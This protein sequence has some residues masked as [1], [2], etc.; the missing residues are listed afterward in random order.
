MLINELRGLACRCNGV[1]L[2]YAVEQAVKQ[3]CTRFVGLQFD[4]LFAFL[5]ERDSHTI[6]AAAVLVL[7]TT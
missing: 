2:G 5:R 1:C 7:H 4:I 6:T 3:E